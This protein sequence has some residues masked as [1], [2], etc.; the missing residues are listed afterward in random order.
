MTIAQ[1]GQDTVGD[2]CSWWLKGM[3]FSWSKR[4]NNQQGGNPIFTRKEEA[5]V[6]HKPLEDF[7]WVPVTHIEDLDEAL[8]FQLW[9]SPA[10]A[11]AAI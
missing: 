4:P 9:P 8:G 6:A 1:P 3:L 10:L 7:I 11:T 2:S 5:A